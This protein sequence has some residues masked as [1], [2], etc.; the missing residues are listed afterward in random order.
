MATAPQPGYSSSQRQTLNK[1]PSE[2]LSH[3]HAILFSCSPPLYTQTSI[4][5][6][7]I[8]CQIKR[9]EKM[10]VRIILKVIS[11]MSELQNIYLLVT[12]YWCTKSGFHLK[13]SSV[14]SPAEN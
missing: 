12:A 6:N 5:T 1:R 13:Y 2:T 11:S 8:L 7:D 3:Q 14:L 10:T 4:D 9:Q